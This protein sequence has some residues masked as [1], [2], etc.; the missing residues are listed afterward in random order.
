MPLTR[1]P[2]VWPDLPWTRGVFVCL[3]VVLYKKQNDR[4]RREH[5]D[6]AAA[7][8]FDSQGLNNDTSLRY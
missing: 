7:V 1:R 4:A 6:L 8:F 2:Y 5:A 3:F